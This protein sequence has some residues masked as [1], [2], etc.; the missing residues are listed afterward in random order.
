MRNC[1]I[2]NPNSRNGKGL[3]LSNRAR[4]YMNRH[5]LD[6]EIYFTAAS[7]DAALIAKKLTEEN[8]D[9]IMNIFVIGGDGTLNEVINGLHHL[10]RI[11]VGYIPTSP[12]EGSARSLGL[13]GNPKRLLN[14]I[15]VMAVM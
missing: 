5:G 2:V 12:K 6:Y 14:G 11:K 8:P 7:G 15:L 1:F 13:T 9:D 10:Q 4:A 3:K